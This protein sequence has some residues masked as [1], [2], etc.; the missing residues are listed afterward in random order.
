MAKETV[1]RARVEPALKENAERVLKQLGLSTSQAITL[2]LKQVELRKGLPFPVEIP[3]SET[4]KTFRDTAKDR[5]LKRFERA[6]ELIEDL[7]I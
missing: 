2:F 4:S 5:K 6:D 1:V 3:C 7:G